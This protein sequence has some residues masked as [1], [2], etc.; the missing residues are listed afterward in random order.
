MGPKDSL[1]NRKT[2]GKLNLLDK[3]YSDKK[4]CDCIECTIGNFRYS[5]AISK[6]EIYE[7]TDKSLL[8]DDLIYA[9]SLYQLEEYFKAYNAYENIKL[10]AYKNK[11]MDVAFLCLYNIKRIAKFIKAAMLLDERYSFK[12]LDEI[13]KSAEKIDLDKELIKLKYFVDEDVFKFLKEIRYGRNIQILCNDI[14]NLF[15]KATNEVKLIKNGGASIN[16]NYYLLYNTVMEL[17]NYLERNFIIGNGFTTITHSI[18]KSIKTFILGYYIGTLK[19]SSYQKSFGISKLESFNEFMFIQIMNYENYEDLYNFIIDH[20]IYDI[21]FDERSEKIV[22]THICNFLSSAYKNNKYIGK[23]KNDLYINYLKYNRNFNNKISRQFKTI[24]IVLTF[25]EFSEPQ[26]KKIYSDLNEFIKNTNLYIDNNYLQKFIFKKYEIIGFELLKETLQIINTKKDYDILYITILQIIKALDL[27]F[28]TSDICYDNLDFDKVNPNFH[29]IYES[30]PVE[31]KKNLVKKLNKYL[32]EKF[33]EKL[34]YVLLLEKIPINNS[35]KN[36][37][38]KY[39]QKI[40]S[41]MIDL[42]ENNNLYDKIN[43]YFELIYLG[44]IVDPKLSSLS[45]NAE[46]VKFIIDPESYDKDKFEVEWL[47]TFYKNIFIKR[48][49]KISY[50]IEKLENYLIANN[51]ERLNKVYFKIKSESNKKDY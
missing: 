3:H 13:E 42:P 36:K 5:D 44:I 28:I 37:Y 27:N 2:E 47:N 39:I 12:D 51:D 4:D 34:I 17:T 21:K 22:A 19:I 14:E 1:G 6:I 15:N 25:F 24:C 9:Y 41:D 26:I 35:L 8:W 16:S 30:I 18:N 50:I 43:N 33:D 48:F 23:Q 31:Q 45:V 20:N 32:D 46:L 7:I 49:S 11:Q 40:L 38:I 10:K 29:L